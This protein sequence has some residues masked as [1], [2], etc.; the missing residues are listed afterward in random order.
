MAKR[1][2][3]LGA[4]APLLIANGATSLPDPPTAWTA[5]PEWWNSG[6]GS[7]A[8]PELDVSWIA[9]AA[10][11]ATSTKIYAAKLFA[12]ALANVTFTDADVDMSTNIVHKAGHGLYT[13]DGPFPVAFD[14]GDAMTGLTAAENVWVIKTDVD[15]VKLASTFAHALAGTAIDL[16]YA[17]RAVLDLGSLAAHAIDIVVEAILPGV[18]GNSITIDIVFDAAAGPTLS[19]VGSAVTLH[20]KDA[21][22]TNALLA[23][24]LNTSTKLRVKTDT[25]APATVLSAATDNFAATALAVAT[26]TQ[27]VT[28]SAASSDLRRMVGCSLGTFGT[29]TLDV[30]QGVTETIN[31]RPEVVA[32]GVSAGL[33]G[34]VATSVRLDP[35]ADVEA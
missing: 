1:L 20:V 30:Q 12:V 29:L 16:D 34:A 7:G 27:G 25:A 3:N 28:L 17:T 23:A 33:S 2:H 26:G 15:H 4:S 8:I 19:E 22:T 24:V 32:Y 18:A 35:V 9:A 11:T 13:G 10:V 31:H 5:V 21:V 6:D 14:T